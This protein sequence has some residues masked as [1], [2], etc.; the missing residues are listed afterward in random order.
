MHSFGFVECMKT[1]WATQAKMM[2]AWLAD[3][4]GLIRIKEV[5]KHVIPDVIAHRITQLE[6]ELQEL[7]SKIKVLKRR[8]LQ[9]SAKG[10]VTSDR[11][12]GWGSQFDQQVRPMRRESTWKEVS[13]NG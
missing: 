12:I 13:F 6:G 3:R 5:V 1:Q 4:F 10:V 7:V 11:E 8:N 9:L 2:V